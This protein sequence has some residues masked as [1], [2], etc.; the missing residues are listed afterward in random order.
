VTENIH[1]PNRKVICA[2]DE[3]SRYHK[4]GN[5]DE[6]SMSEIKDSFLI[7]YMTTPIVF[8]FDI[9]VQS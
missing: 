2:I 3:D 9:Y 6:F 7:F 4:D 5:D 8:I 1:I